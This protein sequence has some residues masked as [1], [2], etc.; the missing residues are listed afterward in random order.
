MQVIIDCYIHPL[1]SVSFV[2][3]I[4]ETLKRSETRKSP[5]SNP[6]RQ[7]FPLTNH[8]HDAGSASGGRL[9]RSDFLASTA[10]LAEPV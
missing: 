4:Y 2:C 7:P 10:H 6:M 1:Q 9:K 8:G 3:H 5:V